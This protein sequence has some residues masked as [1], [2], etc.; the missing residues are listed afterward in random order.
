[1]P[2]QWGK[3]SKS[4]IQNLVPLER[5]QAFLHDTELKG[6]SVRITAS[7]AMSYVLEKRINGRSRRMTLGRY[8]EL[9]PIQAR[10]K[11]QA[12]LGQIAMGNDPVAERRRRQRSLITLE[13]VYRDFCKVRSHLS[14]KTLYDYQRVLKVA[15]PDWLKKPITLITPGMVQD[16]FRKISEQR[17]PDYANLTMRSLRS[18]I[19]F[20]I[21]NYDDGTDDPLMLRN[22]VSV[23]TRT[24]AWHKAQRRQTVLKLHELKPWYEEVEALRDPHD[25]LSF[26]DTMADFQLLLLATGLRRG[27]AQRLKWSDI[28]LADRTMELRKTKNGL[29]V[30]LPLAGLAYEILARRH[31]IV[32]SQYVF[33]GRDGRGPLVEPKKQV[34]RVIDQCGIAYTLHDLRGTFITIAESLDIPPYAI[35]RLVNHKISNDVTA[36]YIVSDIERL[37]RPAQQVSDFLMR[38]FDGSARD[39]LPFPPIRASSNSHR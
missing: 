34:Q 33:P 25:P 23:L 14:D 36:G 4:T 30:T 37:R 31:E 9:T 5:G 29:S 10:K 21:A 13:A 38:A 17:G 12:L 15:L 22:P 11:A 8:S 1:M 27:E 16:R 6:F 39:V 2:N 20:A 24:R 18:L 3:I 19:N 26:G 28:D 7:G 32:T 35:K